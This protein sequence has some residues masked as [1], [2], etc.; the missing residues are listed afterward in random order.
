MSLKISNEK[1]SNLYKKKDRNRLIVMNHL[2][3]VFKILFTLNRE[4]MTP[5][6]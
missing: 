4:K 3:I 6:G 2:N 5:T 1:K